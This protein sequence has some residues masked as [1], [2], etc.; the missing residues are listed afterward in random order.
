MNHIWPLNLGLCWRPLNNVILS[1]Y[2]R[3]QATYMVK[4]RI[5]EKAIR[6]LPSGD[7]LFKR[8]KKMPRNKQNEV[9]DQVQNGNSTSWHVTH[10]G[11]VGKSGS[12]KPSSQFYSS[13]ENP[14]ACPGFL[15]G[16]AQFWLESLPNVIPGPP[17]QLHLKLDLKIGSVPCKIITL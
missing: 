1:L 17:A 16:L 13:A 11:E 15:Y 2:F 5:V 8:E 9:G 6:K 4:T 12:A 7:Q 14:R 3:F 10:S